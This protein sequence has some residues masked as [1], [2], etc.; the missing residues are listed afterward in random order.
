MYLLMYVLIYVDV[1]VNVRV[2]VWVD[3]CGDEVLMYIN[4]CAFGFLLMFMNEF[5]AYVY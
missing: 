2:Y 3:V 1:Y 5:M 4:V